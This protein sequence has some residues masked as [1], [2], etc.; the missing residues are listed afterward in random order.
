M[1]IAKDK[2]PCFNKAAKANH[3]R[4]HLP[5]APQ[6]NIQCGYCNRS[7][8]CVN[9]SRPGVTSTLLEPRQALEYLQR[10]DEK[11][12]QLSVVGIAGPGDVFA[13]PEASLEAMRLVREHFPDKIL[14]ISTNGLNAPPYINDMA[15][16]EVSHI[17]LTIN[18]VDPE[19]SQHIYQWGRYRKR[20][21]RGIEFA[22]LLLDKQLEAIRLL[23]AKGITVKVN[24]IVLPGINDVHITTVAQTMAE[25]GVDTLN[26]LPLYPVAETPLGHLTA[27]EASLMKQIRHEV[28]QYIT[29][30]THCARCRADAAGLL[31]K[32]Q[33]E[34]R[35][36]LQEVATKTLSKRRQ[37]PYVAVGTHEG[38][39]VNQ[40]LGEA[41]EFYIFRETPNGYKLLEQRL[42]PASGSGNQRWEQLNELLHD[43]RAVLVSGI[44]GTP[45][46]ILEKSGLQL[47]EMTGLID[48]GL[49][50][51]YKGKAIK[52]VCKSMLK[53]CG[54]GCS[55]NAQGCA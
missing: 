27:P 47:I 24:T 49:D 33:V 19:I 43:C 29:P 48:E 15:T 10:L 8:D 6:C 5:V 9:E 11:M 36:L 22:R 34:A 18:A 4:V 44:G 7:Y 32:D 41:E 35:L 54:D 1:S 26:P 53:R 25:L 37:Q 39:L 14:C 23:K 28:A 52:T 45:R 20:V 40:H 46:R 55:G 51:L 3:A 2:H 17:T 16:L 30:M 13:Q 12:P 21:Y 31:G 50:H 42:A 38:M